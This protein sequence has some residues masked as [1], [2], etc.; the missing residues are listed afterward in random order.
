MVKA[1]R[2]H[3]TPFS[4][5]AKDCHSTRG[6]GFQD[7]HFLPLLQLVINYSHVAPPLQ[8]GTTDMGT[9]GKARYGLERVNRR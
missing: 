3:Q 5:K 9:E 1:W 7:I 6:D 4:R 8:K 2:F